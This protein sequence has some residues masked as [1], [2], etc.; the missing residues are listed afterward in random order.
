VT[1]TALTNTPTFTNALGAG[2]VVVRYVIEDTVNKKFESGIGSIAANVLTRTDPQVTWDG[3]TYTP[4]SAAALQFGSSPTSGNIRIRLAPTVEA[5]APAMPG[6]NSTIAGDANWRDYPP[7]A[8]AYQTGNGSGSTVTANVEY[9]VA[10][11]VDVGG[12]VNGAQIEVT[13]A[14]AGNMKWA[15]YNI[16]QDGLPGTKIADFTTI[17]TMSTTGVKTDTAFTPF[18]ITPGWYAF[19]L[20]FD[21][22]PG[23]RGA[24]IG[25]LNFGPTPFGRKGTYGYSG[26][27]SIASK[28]YTTGLPAVANM[29]GAAMLDNGVTAIASAWI[30]LKVAS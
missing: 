8:H 20:I 30:G 16:G 22:T 23:V 1:C 26:G 25:T 15:L 5:F 19:G 27:M 4:V 10:H 7:S 17:T 21:S 29:S 11:R 13:N 28:S 14:S 6:R 12:T 18:H 24:G 9:Y 2:A 3:T